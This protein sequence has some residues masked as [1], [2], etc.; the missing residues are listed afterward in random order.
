GWLLASSVG[1]PLVA[2]VVN[3][4]GGGIF[5]F[6]PVAERTPHFE[7]LFATPH[8]VDFAHVAALAGATLHRPASLSALARVVRSGLSGGVHLVE[9]RTERRANVEAHRELNAALVAAGIDGKRRAETLS[10]DEFAALERAL[11]PVR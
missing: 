6:L 10:V 5:N 8:G 7:R 1:A 4:D 9:V 2:V 3:N 11:G